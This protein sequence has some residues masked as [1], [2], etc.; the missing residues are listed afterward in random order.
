[1]SGYPIQLGKV[2]RPPLRDETLA[3][4]RLLDWLDVKI[5]NR[6]VFVT[7]EAGYG[8]TTLLADFSR[9]TRLR[10]LWYRMDEEDRNWVAFLSYLVAAGRIHDPEFASRTS[11]MLEDAGPGG[12]NRDE[13]VE[14][15]FHDLSSI[16]MDGAAL[17]LDDFHV[18][19]DVPDIRHI[20]KLLIERAPERLTLVFASRRTPPVPVARLRAL[21]EMAELLTTD[22]RFSDAE[23]AALFNE[24][25]GR[26]L[27]PDVL[28][29][30]S[31]RTEGWAASLYLVQAALR[32]RSGA[33]TRA[34]IRRLS[35]A[36]SEIYDYL[37]EEVVGDLSEEHQQ[38]LMRTSILQVV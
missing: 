3:R 34:F 19:D 15:F 37:A 28:A 6:V 11:S 27:E 16:A 10:T 32:D 31:K 22:L 23:T 18:A 26:P 14:A 29:D 2:Q 17:I 9:R 13:V 36:H 35:G 8:K 38:F 25:Y 1:M 24:T 30:L 20:A 4:H 12:A 5:H 21:G 33:E 7:A